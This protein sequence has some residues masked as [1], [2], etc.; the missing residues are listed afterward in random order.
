M[1]KIYRVMIC[2]NY[3]ELRSGYEDSMKQYNDINCVGT[4]SSAAECVDKV[5]VLMCFCLIYVWK[6]KPQ[7]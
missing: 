4:A 6:P 7:E 3:E 2:D 1:Q 5:K